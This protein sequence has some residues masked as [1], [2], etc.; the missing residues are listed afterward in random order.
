MRV[1][2]L[3][4]VRQT[5]IPMLLSENRHDKAYNLQRAYQNE[6]PLDELW[7]RGS[8]GP[9]FPASLTPAIVATRLPR[10][11]SIFLGDDRH[12]HQSRH[13]IGPPPPGNGIQKQP[14]Q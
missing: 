4:V 10:S 11:P 5:S 9:C 7:R 3:K 6:N 1:R 13:W 2:L 14:A 12:H 8:G